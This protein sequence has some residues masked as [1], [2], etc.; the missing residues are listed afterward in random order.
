MSLLWT[1]KHAPKKLSEFAGNTEAIKKI[2][3]WAE[4]WVKEKKQKPVLLFGP[5]GSGK[6]LLAELLSREF[7]WQ[8]FEMNASN[9]RSKKEIEKI[10]GAASSSSSFSS[11]K[12]L[13]LIDEVDCMQAQDRGGTTAIAKILRESQNPIILTATDIYSDT[14]LGVIRQETE[15][16]ELKKI[17]YLSIKKRLE[18]IFRKEGIKFEEAALKELAQNSMGDMR[19][20][21]LDLQTISLNGFASK[22]EV[23]S[24]GLREKNTKI[25]SL[26][27]GLFHAKTLQE[28]RQLRASSDVDSEMLCMWVE[29]NLPMQITEQ[30]LATAFNW[31]SKGDL[32]E[33]RIF[34][35]QS[36][37]LKRYSVD[38]MTLVPMLVS[39]K[40]NG[41]IPFRFPSI[42]KKLSSSKKTRQT[43][44]G[45]ALKI[46]KKIHASSKTVIENELV[47]LQ[48]LLE[49]PEKYYKMVK[50][51]D[52]NKEETEFI[53][54]KKNTEKIFRLIEKKEKTKNKTKTTSGRQTTL[55]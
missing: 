34:S 37:E 52:L 21:I 1:E 36:Y 29:E 26:L 50:I 9:L 55:F 6:T 38:L 2:V 8:L 45:I 3:A 42:L 23:E 7:N 13:L 27:S 11:K 14:K 20:A 40:K 16:I 54:G 46:G 48:V 31:M 39:S 41:F 22:K 44:K 51:L 53:A 17:S 28:A 32:F 4:K 49:T 10:A 5:T 24:I 33:G 18:E 43:K 30:H 15:K 19:A 35:R 12:R 47:L 25:F